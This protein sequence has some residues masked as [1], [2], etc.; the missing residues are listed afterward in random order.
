MAR[1]P[2]SKTERSRRA[3]MMKMRRRTKVDE[4]LLGVRDGQTVKDL[5]NM[6]WDRQTER[7]QVS[8]LSGKCE[9]MFRYQLSDVVMMRRLCCSLYTPEGGTGHVQ[10]STSRS[11][12]WLKR[13]FVC[14]TVIYLSKT[15][16]S[17]HE[18]NKEILIVIKGG[19]TKYGFD[20]SSVCSL[21]IL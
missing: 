3:F 19:H 15:S 17:T 6:K 2:L 13:E 16:V 18:A 9:V 8:Y 5:T 7:E 1:T 20:F 4:R 21:C 14:V 10:S 11:E 12:L